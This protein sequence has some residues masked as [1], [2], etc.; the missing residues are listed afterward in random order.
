M[1]VTTPLPIVIDDDALLNSF[2]AA[3]NSTADRCLHP[4]VSV[5]LSVLLAHSSG[6]DE[7]QSK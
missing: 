6:T 4:G 3:R 5:L 1:N 7:Q 2:T